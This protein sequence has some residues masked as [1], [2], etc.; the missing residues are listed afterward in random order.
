MTTRSVRHLG[1]FPITL[2]WLMLLFWVL[3]T[4]RLIPPALQWHRPVLC[5]QVT[6]TVGEPALPVHPIYLVSNVGGA[7]GAYRPGCRCSGS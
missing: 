7:G 6:T 4:P 3:T 5:Q 1:L 2:L